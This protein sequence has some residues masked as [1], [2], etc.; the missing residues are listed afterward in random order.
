MK[1]LTFLFL[2]VFT[3][4]SSTAYAKMEKKGGEM[5]GGHDAQHQMENS[6]M[7]KQDKKMMEQPSAEMGEGHMMKEKEMQQHMMPCM[8]KLQ[9]MMQHMNKMMEKEMTSENRNKMADVMKDISKNMMDMSVM[10]KKGYCTMQEIDKMDKE[11]TET[12]E[13]FEALEGFL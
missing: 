7:M 8:G 2:I 1:K 11:V 13:K 5:S 6:G 12:E 10:M 3:L 4:F 9:N